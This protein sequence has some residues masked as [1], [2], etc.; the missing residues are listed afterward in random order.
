M[1]ADSSAQALTAE[2]LGQIIESSVGDGPGRWWVAYS[3]GVDSTVLLLLLHLLLKANP[4]IDLHAI[5]VDHGLHPDSASWADFCAAYCRHLEVAMT[6]VRIPAP[7]SLGQGMEA[8][9]RQARY[10]AMRE[11]MQSGDLL[12]TAHH[13]DDQAETLLLRLLRGSGPQGLGGIQRRRDWQGI[14]I[15]RPLL[16]FGRAS[17]HQYA[18]AQGLRWLED[19]SNRQQHIDRNYLRHRVLPVLGERWPAHPQVLRRVAENCAD[20]GQLAVDLARLDY[21]HCSGAEGRLLTARLAELSKIRQLNLLRCW[22]EWQGHPPLGR[23]QLEAAWSAL[24]TSKPDANPLFSLDQL[25]MRRYRGEIHL[26]DAGLPGSP[27]ER[28]WSL[29][30]NLYIAE[31]KAVLSAEARRGEGIKAQLLAAASS[32]KLQVRFRQGG[33]S[34]RLGGHRRKLKKLLQEWRLSPWERD[35]IPLLYLDGELIAVPGFAIS[36]LVRANPDEVGVVPIWSASGGHSIARGSCRTDPGAAT[37]AGS[38]GFPL[39]PG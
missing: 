1:S 3:G 25:T 26:L 7:T 14:T 11:N 18:L 20:S 37:A 38:G 9:A 27:A 32:G 12:F 10:Q 21:R 28:D 5:H 33:E 17:I 13:Q 24:V 15:L 29:E 8:A 30:H 31:L 23:R 4:R 16:E 22:L 6:V 2:R 36:D 19:P 34:M 35:R 39:P